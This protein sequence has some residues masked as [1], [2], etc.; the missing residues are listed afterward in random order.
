MKYLLY[1]L[2][3]L[4]IG[5]ALLLLLS[6]GVHSVQEKS[7]YVMKTGILSLLKVLHLIVLA[8]HVVFLIAMTMR[9]SL[10][11]TTSLKAGGR[12]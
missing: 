9:R 12:R 10:K 1:M 4:F 8:K 3:A 5:A 7:I 11:A 6:L 2:L